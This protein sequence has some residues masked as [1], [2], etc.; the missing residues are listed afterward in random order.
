MRK[1]SILSFMQ[2]TENRNR[3]VRI[4]IVFALKCV[5]REVLTESGRSENLWPISGCIVVSLVEFYD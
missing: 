2:F 4:G 5:I 3:W 1:Y